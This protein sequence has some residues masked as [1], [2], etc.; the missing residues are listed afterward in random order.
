[1]AEIERVIGQIHKW[2]MIVAGL[3]LA[4]LLV[5]VVLGQLGVDIPMIR[6]FGPLELVYACGAYWLLRNG[7]L[8]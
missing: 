8:L 2:L 3:C 7:K 4:V 5:A 1:M 6:R